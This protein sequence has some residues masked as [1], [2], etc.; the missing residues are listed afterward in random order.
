MLRQ[1][2]T[3]DPSAN[4]GAHVVHGGLDV[5]RFPGGGAGQVAPPS[6]FRRPGAP[7]LVVESDGK[8]LG[9]LWVSA[10]RVVVRPGLSE[11]PPL[12]GDVTKSWDDG[13]VRLALRSSDGPALRSDALRRTQSTG[14]PDVLSRNAQT[15]IDVRGSYE[16]P[17][18]EANGTAVGWVR[19][20]IG[21]YQPAARIYEASL[22]ATVSPALA[23]AV[24]VA[25]D[26]EIDWIEAQSLNVYKGTDRT[27]PLQESV[28]IHP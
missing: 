20:R 4:F 25:L 6:W 11:T 16:A 2:V 22:P 21:P 12:V 28:P 14:G 3:I 7:A 23:A 17:V 1:P 15:V 18:R 27:G 10:D 5:D 19:V 26:G 13:A 24:A 9:A 8:R